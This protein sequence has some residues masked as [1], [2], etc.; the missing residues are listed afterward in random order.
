VANPRRQVHVRGRVVYRHDGTAINAETGAPVPLGVW[1][2]TGT[3]VDDPYPC[4]CPDES[5]CKRDCPCKGRPGVLDHL[6]HSCC[7]R[8]GR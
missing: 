6:P 3:R 2:A 4:R 7:G 5:R 1:L 8:K